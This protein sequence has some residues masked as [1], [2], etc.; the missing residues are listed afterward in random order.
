[1]EA[2]MEACQT[3]GNVDGE[4]TL[5]PV[6]AQGPQEERHTHRPPSAQ[7]FTEA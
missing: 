1:M 3:N 2:A 4:L 5:L 6:S 7:L